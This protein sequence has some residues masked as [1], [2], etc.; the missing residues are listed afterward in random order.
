[1]ET[2]KFNILVKAFLENLTLVV[3]LRKLQWDFSRK[4]NL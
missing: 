3:K 4:I 2:Y 1:M